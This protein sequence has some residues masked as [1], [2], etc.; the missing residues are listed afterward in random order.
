MMDAPLTFDDLR[1]RA[2]AAAHDASGK[3]WT[4]FNLHDPGVTLL[5]QSVFALSEIAYQGDHDVRDLLTDRDSEID[6]TQRGIFPAD[7]VLSGRPVTNTDLASCLS[8]LPSLERVFVTPGPAAGLVDLV[9]IPRSSVDPQQ[10]TLRTA[11]GWQDVLIAQTRARFDENRMLA[12]AINRIDIATPKPVIVMGEIAIGSFAQPDRI[13]AEIFHQLRLLLKGLSAQRA[14]GSKSLGAT[15]SDVFDDAA[16]LWP[17]L[18]ADAHESAWFDAVLSQ[19][20]DI[21]GVA[22]IGA[23]D[24]LDPETHTSIS[25][26]PLDPRIYFDPILPQINHLVPLR[27]TRDGGAV[28]LN[29]NTIQEELG[30]ITAARIAGQSNRKAQ[31]DW[32]VGHAGKHRQLIHRSTNDSLPNPYRVAATTQNPNGGLT[33]YRQMM[34]RHLA[35]MRAPLGNIPAIYTQNNPQGLH[36]PA[37][38]RARITMLD[39]LIALQGEEMPLCDP[40]CLHRYRGVADRLTWEV[41]WREAYLRDLPAYNHYSGTNHPE[42]GFAARLAHL[43]DLGVATH[44]GVDAITVDAQMQPPAPSIKSADVI[45]PSRPLDAFVKRDDTV[46]PLSL[47]KLAMSCPWVVDARTTP[48]LFQRAAQSDAYIVARN[49]QSDWEVMFQPHSGGD[50]YP[51]GSSHTRKNVEEWANRLRVSFVEMHCDAEKLW[52][53]EDIQLRQKQTDFAPARATLLLPGWTAR[54]CNTSFR[55]FVTDLVSRLAPAH[56]YV[57]IL[58][59]TPE[60][61]HELRPKLGDWYTAPED[62]AAHIRY[63]IQTLTQTARVP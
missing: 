30:R 35:E 44:Q 13:V 57:Q 41:T 34:D 33:S 48:A 26:L 60:E 42:Y 52:L 56:I 6:L 11:S 39:Y 5:E 12:T 18:P 36:D 45:L 23:F 2:I 55:L 8:E 25:Q 32:D 28:V 14:H 21:A 15:R 59:L 3:I 51:C 43:A 24:I 40:D 50:L 20:R 37:L 16:E 22:H 46:A 27:V 19:F 54:T 47:A 31:S 53:F 58:W 17:D 63:A 7:V 4:D 1:A 49:R 10:E 61:T 38:L 9:I 62:N 29:P